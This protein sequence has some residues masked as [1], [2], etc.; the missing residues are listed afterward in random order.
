MSYYQQGDLVNAANFLARADARFE[1]LNDKRRADTQR[2]IK[3]L[4]KHTARLAPKPAASP[5]PAPPQ[6]R[7]P[8]PPDS[9]P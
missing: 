7:L 3:E 6:A 9:N 4:G 5:L 1:Q 2:W 8:L